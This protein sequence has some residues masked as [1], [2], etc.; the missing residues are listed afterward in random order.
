MP[1]YSIIRLSGDQTGWKS[2]AAPVVSG[3]A[4]PPA[5]GTVNRCPRKANATVL[6]SGDSAG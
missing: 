1:A 3:T 5:D 6:P 2:W 4:V